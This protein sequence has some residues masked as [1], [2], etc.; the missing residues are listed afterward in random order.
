L[1]ALPPEADQ[2]ADSVR[3][4]LSGDAGQRVLIAWHLSWAPALQ[5]SRTNWVPALLG[6]LLDDSYAAV[7]CV[8]ARSLQTVSGSLPPGYDYVQDPASRS[9]AREQVWSDWEKEIA[10][11][12]EKAEFP[13]ELLV[14]PEALSQ[15]KVS[16]DQWLKNR[17][18][19][20][21]R[22]RE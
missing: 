12:G 22:L 9:P 1:A 10:M 7:R 16:F 3:L 6:Q 15:Q 5:V 20:R 2:I 13:R 4:A 17:N 19:R 11:K 18:E 8:A 14:Q 21:V